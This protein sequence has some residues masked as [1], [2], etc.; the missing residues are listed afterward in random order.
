MRLPLEPLDLVSGALAHEPGATLGLLQA[1]FRPLRRSSLLLPS[2]GE[3]AVRLLGGIAGGP[4]GGGPRG[5]Q[6]GLG[7]GSQA[8]RLGAGVLELRASPVARPGQG[9]LDRLPAGAR[10][11]CQLQVQVSSSAGG[12]LLGLGQD[13]FDRRRRPVE[14]LGRLADEP[15]CLGPCLLDHRNRVRGCLLAGGRGVRSHLCRGVV[16]LLAQRGD[17]TV[18]RLAYRLGLRGRHLDETACLGPGCLETLRLLLVESGPSPTELLL[19][20]REHLRGLLV[21]LREAG[22]HRRG[23]LAGAGHCHL[24]QALGLR[25]GGRH[26]LLAGAGRPLGDQG[27]LL[28]GVPEQAV[29]VGLGLRQHRGGAGVALLGVGV[30]PG[31]LV[32][33]SLGILPQALGLGPGPA[34]DEVGLLTHRVGVRLRAFQDRLG[35][36][37]DVTD[38]RQGRR[39]RLLRG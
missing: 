7:L 19:V 4:F 34:D 37:G 5:D 18:G 33:E 1:L 29:G 22:V 2:A 3:Q 13:A 28:G 21:G 9:A 24:A 15:V 6:H 23:Q 31:C 20:G 25:P 39:C 27:G 8:L 38:R 12:V 35:V 11:G 16:G 17:L 32:V 30:Q 26:S 36:P 14:L 10:A